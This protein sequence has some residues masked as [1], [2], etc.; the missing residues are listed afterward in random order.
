MVN[1][2]LLG[3][4]FGVGLVAGLVAMYHFN[5]PATKEIVKEV[6]R[7]QTR[8]ITQ[9]VKEPSGKETTT[10]VVNEQKEQQ[11]EATKTTALPNWAVGG[12]YVPGKSEGA[13]FVARRVIGT[14]YA[15][16]FVASD[17]AVGVTLL[18][19]F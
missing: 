9:I 11:K 3:V 14:V 1:K 18:L 15:G 8:T 7:Q 5:A 12:L 16:G 13:I 4:S 19:T 6:V 10:I 17:G 2:K